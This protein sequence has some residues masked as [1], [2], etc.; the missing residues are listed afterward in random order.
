MGVA[1]NIGQTR[2]VTASEILYF[3]GVTILR[4]IDLKP[5]PVAVFRALVTI[6][7]V[8]KAGNVD[9]RAAP[10]NNG[11]GA[12]SLCRFRRYR[13]AMLTNL[14]HLRVQ[15][16]L[17]CE[18]PRSSKWIKSPNSE[19]T[20]RAS[21]LLLAAPLVLAA[22]AFSQSVPPSQSDKQFLDFA[23]QVN[24]GEI[25]GGVVAQ[26]KA[27]APAVKA[28]GRLM[29]LDHSELESQLAAIAAMD[30]VQL[31]D[32][33]S[34]AA[35]Q[36][37]DKLKSMNGSQFDTAYMKHMVEGHETAVS[38]FK[39]EELSAQDPTVRAVVSSAL[40]IIEQH[41]AIAKAV[42]ASLTSQQNAAASQ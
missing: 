29:M 6:C 12:A 10:E 27:Q 37:M 33:P 5:D 21:F 19:L 16:E 35:E 41:L 30:H 14:T 4:G 17:E 15:E 22:P 23:S 11:R 13:T 1:T 39:S 38:K 2:C 24:V 36:Q 28:F 9:R 8:R 42:Q 3:G 25:R 32:Q 31:Q 26:Q 18:K 7:A 20:M 40:P 34:T